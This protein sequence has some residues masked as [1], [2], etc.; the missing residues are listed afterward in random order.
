MISLRHNYV[1][2]NMLLR[3]IRISLPISCGRRPP[4][5]YP[6][7]SFIEIFFITEHHSTN[8]FNVKLE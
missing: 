7:Q 8:E 3:P 1:N 4:Q 2:R 6:Q 5:K